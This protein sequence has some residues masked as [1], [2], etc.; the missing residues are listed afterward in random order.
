MR[1]MQVKPKTLMFGGINVTFVGVKQVKS[2]LDIFAYNDGGQGYNS[3]SIGD[4]PEAGYVY[5]L[6]LNIS[7]AYE[8]LEK[9][10]LSNTFLN[11]NTR[12]IVFE[13]V[14]VD[15]EPCIQEY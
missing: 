1:H 9:L 15:Y 5:D 7:L 14:P 11:L 6:P 8:E 12:A 3:A 4:V 10:K 13:F 2:M